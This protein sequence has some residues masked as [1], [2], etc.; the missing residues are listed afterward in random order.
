MLILS[1]SKS[2]P[3]LDILLGNITGSRMKLISFA[4]ALHMLHIENYSIRYLV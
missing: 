4:S 1:F 3:N 2:R